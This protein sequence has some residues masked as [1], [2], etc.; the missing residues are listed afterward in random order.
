MSRALFEFRKQ[1]VT[2]I[3]A[4]LPT[5]KCSVQTIARH[6]GLDRTTVSRRL[7][8]IGPGYSHLRQAIRKRRAEELRATHYPLADIAAQLGF[9]SADALARWVK[10]TYG[11]PARMWRQS[12]PTA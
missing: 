5:G 11:Y 1:V 7:G 10:E 3:E 6:V 2:L 9:P 8:R 4:Y 12:S